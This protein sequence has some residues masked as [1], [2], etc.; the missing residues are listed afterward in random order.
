VLSARGAKVVW[1]TLPCGQTDQPEHTASKQYL[2][3]HQIGGVAK[4]RPN[5][6]RVVDLNLE[7]CPGG[8]FS[9]SYG[10]VEQARPDGAHFSDAGAEA[11]ADWLMKQ[12]LAN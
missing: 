8:Q 9:M 7:V 5:T 10:G 6:V 3:G 11:V 1:L 4:R 2:N 12:V